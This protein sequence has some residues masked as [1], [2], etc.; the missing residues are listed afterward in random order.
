MKPRLARSPTTR[1]IAGTASSPARTNADGG[2]YFVGQHNPVMA[3]TST[4]RLPAASSVMPLHPVNR[5]ICPSEL[6]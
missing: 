2:Y 1:T 6:R 4:K 3:S 5:S